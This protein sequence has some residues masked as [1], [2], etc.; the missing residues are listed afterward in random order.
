MKKTQYLD[1]YIQLLRSERQYSPHTCKN[2]RRDLDN[3]SNYLQ[4]HDIKQWVEV[5]YTQVSAYAAYRFR[6]GLKSRTIQ[7][8]LSSIR[9]FYQ[10]L[11]QQGV[12]NSNPA[13]DV[14]APKPD[15]PLPK[16]CDAEQISHL[17]HDTKTD[18][19][20][21]IRDLAIF[22]LIYSSGLRLAEL[23]GIDMDD[24][25]QQQVIV[26]GKGRKMRQL[27]IGSKAIE[28]INRWLKV[29]P[30]FVRANT[31]RA[32]FLSKLGKRISHRNVQARLNLLAKT[33]TPGQHLS[34]H[35]LRHS[36]A[37]H[38]LEASGDLR[39]VQELLGHANIA[40]TQ[41]YTHLDFQHLARVYDL[42][43]PRAKKQS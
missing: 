23:V 2:Y 40:T 37:T 34:P 7:R 4:A 41:I 15:Q 26:T 12:T 36:F 28:A 33:H 3:F 25:E 42:A 29:R 11:I 8:E 6:N 35:M 30:G 10:Y 14:S 17:L 16:T 22:E 1:A 18:S 32:L 19:D 9:G 27:P 20:L 39:S 24:I 5:S 38:M 13:I 21:T 43:H 31:D